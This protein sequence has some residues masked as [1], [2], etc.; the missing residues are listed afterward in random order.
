YNAINRDIANVDK[1]H[2]ELNNAIDQVSAGMAE[3]TRADQQASKDWWENEKAEAAKIREEKQ[4]RDLE[5]EQNKENERRKEEEDLNRRNDIMREKIAQSKPG[6][7]DYMHNFSE[8]GLAEVT[9]E[10]WGV[11]V[12]CGFIDKTGKEIVPLKYDGAEDFS[13][14]LAM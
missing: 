7:Y 4:Q 8:D 10:V 3:K 14:G 5:W 6:A 9:I 12:K 2:N 13:E 11:G 1:A